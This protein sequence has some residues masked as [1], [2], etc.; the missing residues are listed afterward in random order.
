VSKVRLFSVLASIVLISLL[1]TLYLV[2][3]HVDPVEETRA[4][5][6]ESDDRP[7]EQNLVFQNEFY[8]VNLCPDMGPV[9]RGI[10]GR[11]IVSSVELLY[12]YGRVYSVQDEVVSPGTEWINLC[13]ISGLEPGD[14][15]ALKALFFMGRLTDPLVHNAE[16]AEIAGTE[17]RIVP[18]APQKFDYGAFVEKVTHRGSVQPTEVSHTRGD[19][20]TILRCVYT[21]PL[22]EITVDYLLSDNSPRITVRTKTQYDTD[23]L[24]FEESLRINYEIPLREVYSRNRMVDTD[25]FQEEYWLE[26]QGFLA[27][28]T[29]ESLMIYH[30]PSVSSLRLLPDSRRAHVKL[31]KNTDRSFLHCEGTIRWG[32]AR[33]S[34]EYGPGCTRNNEFDILV[35]H[36][37]DFV[38]R[39]MLHPH[40]YLATH[41]WTEHPDGSTLESN[42]AVNGHLGL[43]IFGHLAYP[44]LLSGTGRRWV[45]RSRCS[46]PV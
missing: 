24:V 27:Y 46:P 34:S 36:R 32:T 33:H 2:P 17:V 25:D 11:I 9:I 45:V 18:Q 20:L 4:P 3:K 41:I 42:R 1:V 35:G 15:V 16:I 26:T 23:T 31:D 28:D 21:T 10:D 44:L 38:P 43:P 13:C 5:H 29:D 19:D 37:P 8:S 7:D 6:M 40:G 39:L 12:E 22:S 14:Q 30:A